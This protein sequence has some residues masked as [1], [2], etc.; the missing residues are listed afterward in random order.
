MIKN[1]K[2]LIT[3]CFGFVAQHLIFELLNNNNYIVGIYNKKYQKNI[4]NFNNFI[5]KKK[6]R[7][8]KIDVSDKLK[9]EKMIKENKFHICFHLAAVSQVLYASNKPYETYKSNLIGTINILE[10]FR[11]HNKKTKIIFSSSDK[12]YG[13]SNDLP[14]TEDS[15]LNAKNIYDTSKAAADLICRSYSHTYK[16]DV[17]IT[18]FVNIYGKG[19][20]NWNRIIPGTIKSLIN[21]KKPII[22]SNGKFKRDYLHIDDVVRGYLLIAKKLF[23]KNHLLSGK[24]I[25][26]GSNNPLSVIDVVKIILRN[27]NKK[28][29]YYKIL[30]KSKNEIKD[31][32]SNYKLALKL[33]NW[34]PKIHI[35]KGINQLIDWYKEN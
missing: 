21:N 25:N 13:D 32:Y 12:V 33:L 26:F 23:N 30:D 29:N 16:M 20:V 10:L 17:V 28:N 5:N 18:R 31:Q 9:L 4:Y 19:D 14:Y 7:I 6:Y 27:F 22:R 34:K 2:I 24:S 3:G 15:A 8:L 1:K 35:N 11:I